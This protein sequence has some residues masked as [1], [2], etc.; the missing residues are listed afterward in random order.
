MLVYCAVLFQSISA[1]GQTLDSTKIS[2]GKKLKIELDSLN[3]KLNTTLDAEEYLSGYKS[4]RDLQRM[5]RDLNKNLKAKK[6]SLTK[7]KDYFA[8]RSHLATSLPEVRSKR[9]ALDKRSKFIRDSIQRVNGLIIS[10]AIKSILEKGSLESYQKIT[11]SLQRK[12]DSIIRKDSVFVKTFLDSIRGFVHMY[13]A[14]TM[15]QGILKTKVLGSSLGMIDE[16]KPILLFDHVKQRFPQVSSEV[17]S[18]TNLHHTIFKAKRILVQPYSSSEIE[19]VRGELLSYKGNYG[20][21]IALRQ[22]LQKLDQYCKYH[23]K[24]LIYIQDQ[25]EGFPP[26]QRLQKFKNR[27]KVEGYSYLSE[28][29][30]KQYGKAD[31]NPLAYKPDCNGK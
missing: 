16:L 15:A 12:I 18:L 11:D 17:D 29:L 14:H 10:K 4:D 1:N 19:K 30:S 7:L 6:D 20:M 24:A 13:L 21:P 22:W 8:Q 26:D 9:Y 23:Y 27:M 5:K 3:T 25:I 31:K 28:L 2:L